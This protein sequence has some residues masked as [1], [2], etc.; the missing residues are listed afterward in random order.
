MLDPRT[1]AGIVATNI[2]EGAFDEMEDRQD[3]PTS[4]TS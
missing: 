2:M 4:S 3:W 1:F